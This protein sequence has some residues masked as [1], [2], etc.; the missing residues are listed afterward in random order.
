M[1]RQQFAQEPLRPGALLPLDPADRP[2]EQRF[3]TALRR[4]QTRR[5][6]QSLL[7]AKQPDQRPVA[8]LRVLS[9]QRR[10]PL[11]A[12]LRGAPVDA[13]DVRTPLRQQ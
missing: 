12:L 6:Q 11:V 9:E 8:G 2:L 5:Q 1:A 10:V 4:P 13:A 3:E 7:A